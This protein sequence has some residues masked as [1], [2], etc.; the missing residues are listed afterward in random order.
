MRFLQAANIRDAAWPSPLAHAAGEAGG[1]APAKAAL[2][3]LGHQVESGHWFK[4]TMLSDQIVPRYFVMNG[5]AKLIRRGFLVLAFQMH[6]RAER[7]RHILP[8]TADFRRD[9]LTQFFSQLDSGR[10][11]DHVEKAFLARAPAEFPCYGASVL[12]FGFEYHM[13]FLSRTR[14][15]PAFVY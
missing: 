11:N 3:L 13:R 1:F 8:H 12:R 6:S 14:P 4:G 7:S 15:G 5:D 10:A 9:G 2:D